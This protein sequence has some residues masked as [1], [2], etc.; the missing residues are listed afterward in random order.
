MCVLESGTFIVSPY[1][2][3]LPLIAGR[4]ACQLRAG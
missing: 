3:A 1:R 2:K 4:P